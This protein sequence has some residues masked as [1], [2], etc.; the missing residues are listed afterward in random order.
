M[1]GIELTPF[2]H[3]EFTLR[4]DDVARVVNC[5]GDTVSPGGW[6]RYRRGVPKHRARIGNIG[7]AGAGAQP[8]KT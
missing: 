2:V 8:V 6:K 5:A 7:D 1:I 4:A 3:D